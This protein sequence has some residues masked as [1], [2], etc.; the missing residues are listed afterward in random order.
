MATTFIPECPELSTEIDTEKVLR[1]AYDAYASNVADMD[2]A[3]DPVDHEYYGGAA[4]GYRSVIRWLT[5]VDLL[6]EQQKP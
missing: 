6:E 5:G 1:S 3:G 2:K 4:D